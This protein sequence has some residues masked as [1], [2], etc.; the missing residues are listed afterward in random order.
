MGC[1]CVPLL[2]D[3][4]F[5]AL[6]N[7][8]RALADNPSIEMLA[9]H[10]WA[11]SW[12]ATPV[13][14]LRVVLHPLTWPPIWATLDR[15]GFRSLFD[16]VEAPTGHGAIDGYEV[17]AYSSN[18]SNQHEQEEGEP[19]QRVFAVGGDEHIDVVDEE[20]ERPDEAH[21][22]VDDVLHHDLQDHGYGSLLPAADHHKHR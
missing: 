7:R 18:A 16:K 13:A 20:E 9:I 15:S 10:I 21:G 11:S 5:C 3:S 17:G 2:F 8:M 22:E 6:Q 4:S 14:A 19:G 1:E 12:V